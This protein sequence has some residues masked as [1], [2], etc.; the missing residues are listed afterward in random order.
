MRDSVKGAN[1]IEV[2]SSIQG[3]G[4]Y[5][6]YRQ[7]FVRFEGCNLKCDYC[8]TE[9]EAGSHERCRIES[10]IGSQNFSFYDNPVDCDFLADEINS[11]L[12][13]LPHHAASITGGEPLMESDYLFKLLPNI[14]APILLET[15]GTMPR[16]LK[17][18]LPMVDIISMDIKLPSEVNRELWDLHRDFLRIASEKDLY[19]K[20]VV[21]D[22]TKDDEL[23]KAFELIASIDNN[24]PLILQPV[25][26]KGMSNKPSAKKIMGAQKI[27]LSALRDVRIIPQTHVMMNLL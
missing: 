27:A 13:A 6:G 15:N 24:I 12:L 3:E 23:R 5:V 8:D 7:L 11:M 25:T 10:V 18:L 17:M 19:V 14:N 16:E 20:I 9:H 4:K 26:P 21:A 1:V 22:E 2:F